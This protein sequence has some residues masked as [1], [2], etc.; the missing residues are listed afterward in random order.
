MPTGIRLS[1]IWLITK[2]SLYLLCERILLDVALSR[3]GAK[4]HSSL[5]SLGPNIIFT[6]I[7][8]N[9]GCQFGLF[10]LQQ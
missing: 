5:F 2:G 8:F 9:T 7:L 1:N 6:L 3:D 10:Y 4:L